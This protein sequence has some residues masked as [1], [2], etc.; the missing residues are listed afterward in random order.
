MS[1]WDFPC[2]P[3]EG[4]FVFSWAESYW[5]TFPPL[6][7]PSFRECVSAGLPPSLAPRF[8]TGAFCRLHSSV[9][10]WRLGWLLAV[11]MCILSLQIFSDSP[12]AGTGLSFLLV[13]VGSSPRME[14]DNCHLGSQV[15]TQN[16]THRFLCI[17]SFGTWVWNWC[18]P[19]IPEKNFKDVSLCKMSFLV[20]SSV[21]FGK[22][23]VLEYHLILHPAHPYF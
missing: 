19:A 17:Y 13:A 2:C 5:L 14:E 23:S 11:L 6:I 3:F 10:L 21:S 1:P 8:P 22:N 9:L 7:L 12:F 18:L 4:V 15:L 16:L 20:S